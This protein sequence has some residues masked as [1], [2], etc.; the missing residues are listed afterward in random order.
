M[1]NKNLLDR[2]IFYLS[3]PKCVCCGEKLD[4]SDRAL[5]KDCIP[6]YENTKK[7]KCSVCG[8]AYNECVCTNNYLERHFVHKLVKIFSYT[9]PADAHEKLAANELIYNLKRHKRTDIIDFV[10]DELITALKPHLKEREYVI[11][12]V[13]RQRPRIIKYG[14]DHS[15]AI[16]KALAKKLKFEYIKPLTSTSKTPQKKTQG[17]AR[18]ENA[19]FDYVYE[20]NLTGEHI[21]LVDDI[22]TTGASMGTCAALLKGLGAKKII[23]AAISVAYKDTYTPFVTEFDKYYK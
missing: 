21:I 4:I 8:N 6:S 22:V 14:F 17:E 23:G 18:V 9:P 12:S 13:P 2:I 16:A 3:V 20:T 10:T 5:C 15:E 1:K 19:K 7:K 11:T